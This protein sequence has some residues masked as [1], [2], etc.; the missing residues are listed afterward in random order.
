MSQGK[1]F[2]GLVVLAAA[3]AAAGCASDG[4]GG[5][6]SAS[7]KNDYADSEPLPGVVRIV[8]IVRAPDGKATYTLS[9]IS[10]KLQEDLACHVN[11][12]YDPSV[13]GAI[14]VR[15]NR[16]VSPERDL[17]LLK[18]D[19]AKDVVFENPRPGQPVRATIIEV[20]DS[21][22]VAAVAR[23]G[24]QMGTGTT[25]LNRALECVGMASEDEIR[26]GKLWIDVENVSGRAVTELEAKAVFVDPLD[27]DHAKHGETKWTT[28]KDVK[29]GART[30]IAFNIADL[31]RVSN[32]TFLVKIRQQSL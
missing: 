19:T 20:Q 6:G 1:R 3:F 5:G 21:P 31:G 22:P 14:A 10:G 18:S 13:D 24:A 15:E 4:S 16:E 27:K 8:K 2:I 26:D 29:P 17:V 28:V 30:R 23:D 9:N 25:F 11:F 32:Y 7:V 12:I